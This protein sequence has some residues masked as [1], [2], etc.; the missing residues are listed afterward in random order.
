MKKYSKRLKTLH[1]IRRFLAAQINM[2]DQG[3]IDENRL[4]C[5]SYALSILAGIIRDSDLETRVEAL[6]K[7]QAERPGGFRHA[8]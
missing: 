8:N 2:L 4:R 1:D 7:L 6:E 5:I 3:N